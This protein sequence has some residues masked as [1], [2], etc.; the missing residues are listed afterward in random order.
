[1]LMETDASPGPASTSADAPVIRVAI[2]E[3]QDDIREGLATL[4]GATP[5]Y[6]CA[7]AWPTIEHAL[8]R[9]EAAEPDVVLVDLGLPG[10]GGIEGIRRLKGSRPAVL[11]V[12]LTV[13]QDDDRIFQA[14]CAGACGYLLKKTPAPQL[15]A[16]VADAVRGGAP[17]SPEI[18]RRVVGLFSR[19][20]PAR[21]ADYRLTPHETRVLKLLVEGHSYKTAAAALDVST[22]T[23][24]FHLRR[25]YEKLQVHSKT[26]AVSKALRD[27]LL[28]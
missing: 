23:V 16:G 25:V 15:L 8:P 6:S 14:L 21:H 28:R 20:E 5:G 12:V 4:I 2:V 7:G 1:M 24:A 19:F 11:S 27:G 17:M 3:D 22:A 26:E 13:Y 18:A 10:M 9:L